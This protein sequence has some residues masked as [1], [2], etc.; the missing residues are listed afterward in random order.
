MKVWNPVIDAEY[1]HSVNACC[2][3][4]SG[5]FLQPNLSENLQGPHRQIYTLSS[6]TPCC[7]M[8]VL[9]TQE[10]QAW[11]FCSGLAF[12][13]H[14]IKKISQP[15]LIWEILLCSLA[16][17]PYTGIHPVCLV[18]GSPELDP[19]FQVWPYQCWVE[20]K[21]IPSQP[22]GNTLPNAAQDC[23]SLLQRHI[24]GSIS[25]NFLLP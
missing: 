20:G 21:E 15:F 18:L 22:A 2:M 17:W 5:Y 16:L 23:L 12:S 13:W 8:A 6:M 7:T 25:Q 24:S 1:I 10:M 14:Q 3:I 9:N 19:A 11:S 4:S